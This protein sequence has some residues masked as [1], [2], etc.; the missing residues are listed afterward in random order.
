MKK[1]KSL[2]TNCRISQLIDNM[3]HDVG[4]VLCNKLK[5]NSFSKQVELST[6][7]V[8]KCHILA[9]MKFKNNSETYFFFCFKRAVPKKQKQKSKYFSFYFW[10]QFVS[11]KNC[12]GICTDDTS[13]EVFFSRKKENSKCDYNILLFLYQKGAQYQVFLEME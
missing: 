4:K 2:I 9:F 3:S 11:Q 13:L 7:F 1:L 10:K 6:D 12:L 5:T 8:S